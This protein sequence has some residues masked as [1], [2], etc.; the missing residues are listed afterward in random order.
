MTQGMGISALVRAW[1]LTSKPRYIAAADRALSAFEV[2]V[3]HGGLLRTNKRGD[4]W[5][6]GTP[7]L[8]GGQVLNQVLFG[9][10]GLYE[11]YRS[12]GNIRAGELFDHGIATIR[13]HL[14]DFDFNLLFFKWCKYDNRLLFGPDSK[15]SKIQIEQLKW[16]SEAI[17][18]DLLASHYKKWEDWDKEF[19]SR[20]LPRLLFGRIWS[21]YVRYFLKYYTKY[22][23]R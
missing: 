7:S 8:I 4:T 12:T 11:M 20:R 13:R 2:P 18:D 10:I 17:G 9:L 19:S 5:Y 1:G 22:F 6:E 16:I 15:Y 23:Q 3:S 14:K 21:I